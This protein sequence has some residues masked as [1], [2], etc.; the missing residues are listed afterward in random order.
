MDGGPREEGAV[1]GVN[2]LSHGLSSES[3]VI[4][5]SLL[6][7]HGCC[8][9]LGGETSFHASP[10]ACAARGVRKRVGAPLVRWQ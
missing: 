6:V 7:A 8:L 5:L 9:R 1:G 10:S 4:G 2:G 3:P